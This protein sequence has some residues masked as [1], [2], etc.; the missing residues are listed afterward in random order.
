MHEQR[1]IEETGQFHLPDS[2]EI[3]RKAMMHGNDNKTRERE[4]G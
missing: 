1:Y 4:L 3:G 2:C